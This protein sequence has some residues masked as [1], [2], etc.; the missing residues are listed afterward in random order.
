MMI[1]KTRRRW[2]D[3]YDL[4][5]I[6][7]IRKLIK[8]SYSNKLQFI[9]E[10]HQ[11]FLDGVEYTCVSDIVKKWEN[12]DREAM[13]EGCAAKAKWKKDYKYYG[14]TK[15]EIRELWDKNKDE[16]CD[17]GTLV[18]GFG[19]SMF[20]WMIGEDDKILPEYKE[21]FSGD[22]PIA[23]NKHEEAVIQFW[24]DIPDDFVPVLAETKVFNKEGTPYAGTF[25]ILFYY[26]KGKNDPRNGLILMDYKGLDV[27]TPILTTSGWKT[28][29]T[30][31][32]GDIVFDKNGEETTVIHTS[33][34]HNNPCFKISFNDCSSVIA[35][36][37]HRWEITFSRSQGKPK[38]KIMTTEEIFDF[39]NTHPNRSDT[40][41][42]PKICVAKS[43]GSEKELPIDPYI[44]GVWLG[45][46]HAACGMVTNMYDE[47]FEEIEKRGFAV[48]ND[49]S[50]G[51][52]GKAK[53]R[54]VYG[55]AK[56]LRENGL[57]K[58]KH[59]PVIYLTASYEQKLDLLRGLMDTDGYYNKTRKRFVL[60]TTRGY[61]RD[62]CLELLSSMGVKAT[63]VKAMKKCN[64]KKIPGFDISFYID[65]YPF[66]SRDIKVEKPKIDKRSFKN[67]MKIEPVETVET[68]CIEVDSP[69]HTFLFGKELTVTHNTNKEL[70][71]DYVRSTG[72]MMRAPFDDFFDDSL[73][74]YVIQLGLYSIPLE[75]LGLKVIGRR[76]IWL[77]DDGSY[78]KLKIEREVPRIKQALNINY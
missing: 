41:N 22:E 19:E 55:L 37:E 69:T 2:A 8:D 51:G 27:N 32:E 31:Q 5:E 9:E 57:I 73:Q 75:K 65:D 45:D 70:T 20:Y 36:H 3:Y 48:G 71:N 21:Q 33:K 13:L 4:P 24:K 43:I 46:G 28:M 62:F 26:Y 74:H 72:Q 78:E 52:S 58:N 77:C 44:L 11:Y 42:I 63:V 10:T 15:D 76:V 6:K 59:V 61:Q 35:D 29:G 47:I 54:T 68:R 25:D 1:K 53:T 38:T 56:K 64:G 23:K 30:I 60:A 12:N 66:L 49:V 40:I 17:F 50:G 39:M 67:I 14:M 18:H 16:A 7:K 34:I